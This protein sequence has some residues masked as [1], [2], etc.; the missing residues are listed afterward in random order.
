MTPVSTTTTEAVVN[1]HLQRFLDGDLQGVVS[2]Y[3][4]DAVMIAPTGVLR[5]VD[6]IRPLFEALIAEFARPG[7]TFDLQQQVVENDLA[8]IRWVAETA[9]NTYDIG[10]DTFVVR[11]GKILQQTFAFKATPKA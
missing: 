4:P 2:D 5:G 7:A 6:S 10:T 1:N 11:D 3:A 8:Y 9:D